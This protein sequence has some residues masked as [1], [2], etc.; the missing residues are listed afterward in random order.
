[1]LP[2][3]VRV[4]FGSPVDLSPYYDRPIDRPLLEEVTT[5]LMSQIAAL[6]PKKKPKKGGKL[7]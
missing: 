5:F 3:R 6:D 7:P 2:S 4:T 1:L